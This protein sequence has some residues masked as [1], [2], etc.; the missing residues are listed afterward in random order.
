MDLALAAASTFH[1]L[2]VLPLLSY[3]G[4]FD[5]RLLHCG[6]MTLSEPQKKYLRGLGHHLKPVIVVADSGLSEAVRKE[7]ESTIDHHELIKVQ[8]RASDRESRDEI[9]LQ[10]CDQN[11]SLVTRIGNVALLFR[12]NTEKPRI[13]V[14]RR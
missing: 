7:F 3:A 8:V 12:R 14:P 1:C 9:V 13:K 2:I 10:L 5:G 4:Y 11:T 6:R